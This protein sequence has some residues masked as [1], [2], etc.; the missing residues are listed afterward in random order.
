MSA[1]LCG[2]QKTFVDEG[3]PTYSVGRTIPA[4]RTVILVAVLFLPVGVLASTA[5]ID[6]NDLLKKCTPLGT[7]GRPAAETVTESLDVGYCA[8]YIAGVT[9]VERVWE[10]VEGNTS[11]STHYCM[12]KE[13]TNGQAPR[14]LKK[15]LEDNPD[16]LHWRADLIIHKALLQAFPC[17]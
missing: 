8:G 10:G 3:S 4:M 7:D 13:A 1:G 15:W 11:Q 14:I 17:K 5:Q 6:G 9:D 12:P 2:K 16:K